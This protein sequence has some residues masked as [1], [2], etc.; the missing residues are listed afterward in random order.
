MGFGQLD[1]REDVV[2]D[3]LF[4]TNIY[5]HVK[6]SIFIGYFI[7]CKTRQS[8][9][10]I[11][12][13]A[14]HVNLHSLFHCMQN[15]SIFI[16]YFIACKTRQSSQA[17]SLH[18]K[19]VN[20]HS[21]FH[22]MQN[23]SIFIGYFIACKTR[24]S[25]QA[26]SLRAKHVN[27]HRLFHCMQNTSIFIAY[28]IACKTRQSSQA[29]SLRA[30]HVNLHRLFHCMQNTSIFI[31]YF[32]A[33]KKHQSSYHISCHLHGSTVYFSNNNCLKHILFFHVSKG[34][35]A[36]SRSP[37]KTCKE[38]K[39]ALGSP[40]SKQYWIDPDEGDHSNAF[41]VYCEMGLKGGGWTLVWSYKFSKFDTFNSII[42]RVYPVPKGFTTQGGYSETPPTSETDYK[43]MNYSLWVKI[44][45]SFLLKSNINNQLCCRPNNN[46]NI[47]T[48]T[49]GYIS[50]S[51]DT[52]KSN[53]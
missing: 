33:C 40:P 52:K 8:S 13:R 15:T 5:L 32:I 27:L 34:N 1:C 51:V 43:A 22:C 23:T 39:A 20:L 31:G 37:A 53:E 38:I 36:D 41:E 2:N 50:C 19:H 49:S 6:T 10:A 18:A 46:G 14:K 12:L 47:A 26:I 28:F 11:S 48:R 4:N 30:K 35:G 9:Q 44:G 3:L 17:I 45:S 42:N 29:I 25:S 24:Q 21:L 7:A 16:G